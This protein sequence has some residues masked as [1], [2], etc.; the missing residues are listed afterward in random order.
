MNIL[1]ACLLSLFLYQILSFFSP[2]SYLPNIFVLS[3]SV[4]T[5]F[6]GVD[7]YLHIYASI[8][9][10]I[11][12][13]SFATMVG[14]SLGIL[15][16]LYKKFT[17]ITHIIDF[18]RPIPPIAWIP[19]SI[20]L[21]GLGDTSAYFIVFLGAVFPIFTNTYTGAISMPDIYRNVS[22]TFEISGIQ[23]VRYVLLGYTLPYIFIGLRVGI[24][25]AWMSVIAA[26]LV[27]AQSGLGYY[28]QMNRLLLQT[29]N[30]LIG[31]ICIGCIGFLLQS[32]MMY[33]EKRIIRW[34]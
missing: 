31:M 3:Q 7:I 4:I 5:V 16:A 15:C 9:R 28:I 18:L 26:E 12:G 13:F 32:L 2:H 34:K 8:I 10:I 29:E 23:Y 21:F 17:F 20:L 1:V 14:V 30:I 24:G 6:S 19:L 27:G 25:M 11:I 33:L 22:K